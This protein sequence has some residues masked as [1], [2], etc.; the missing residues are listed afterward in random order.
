MGA[1]GHHWGLSADLGRGFLHGRGSRS[2]TQMF[3]YPP[4]EVVLESHFNHPCPL[5]NTPLRRALGEWAVRG[6]FCSQTA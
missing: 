4:L 3:R 5:L 1:W 6:G 2:E